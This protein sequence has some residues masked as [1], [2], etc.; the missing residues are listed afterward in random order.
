M[1]AASGSLWGPRGGWGR[2]FVFCYTSP[3]ILMVFPKCCCG[4]RSEH[5]F[6][7]PKPDL[8]WVAQVFPKE[9]VSSG[10]HLGPD[11][12]PFRTDFG[13]NFDPN[14]TCKGPRRPLAKHSL[15]YTARICYP[16]S[17]FPCFPVSR[18]PC[19]PVSQFPCFPVSF[20]YCPAWC[21]ARSD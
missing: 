1:K 21:H 17:L 13:S 20:S 11:R 18:F 15:V 8:N 7:F 12:V 5:V 3:V 4:S 19:F 6:V 2:A 9:G 16:V 14:Q 10:S